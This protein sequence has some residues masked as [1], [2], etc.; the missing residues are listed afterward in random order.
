MLELFGDKVIPEHDPDPRALHRPV[1]GDRQAEV[2]HLQ[3]TR[4]PTSSG[5]RSFRS[6][7]SSAREPKEAFMASD[8]RR[9]NELLRP[10]SEPRVLDGVYTDDQ[11]ERML[12]VVKR[13]GPW[14]TI[15]AHHF[16]TR[17]RAH[18]DLDRRR[19]P[20]EHG[21]T[22]DDVA[23][24]ALPRLLRQELGRAS[25]R[26]RGL[27]LQQRVPR[28]WSRDYWDARVRASRR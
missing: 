27:L 14:R 11:H 28:S 20:D 22:L 12:D 5:R 24:R 7:P 17:R 10:I 9:L 16:E 21:L 2:P 19:D 4:S 26:A 8:A 18:R 6:P 13:E 23:D 3:P 15:I 1:P 25:T